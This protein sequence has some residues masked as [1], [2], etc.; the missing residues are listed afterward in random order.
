MYCTDNIV[1]PII[2]S[3]IQMTQMTGHVSFGHSTNLKLHHVISIILAK[4]I[5]VMFQHFVL[6]DSSDK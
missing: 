1:I 5:Y 2:N 3:V 6:N 4:I